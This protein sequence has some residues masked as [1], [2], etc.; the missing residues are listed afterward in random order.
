MARVPARYEVPYFPCSQRRG[1]LGG[2]AARLH[3]EGVIMADLKNAAM[4]ARLNS[5]FSECKRCDREECPEYCAEAV[6]CHLDE[7]I[8]WMRENIEGNKR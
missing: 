5:V 3:G 4:R 8:D 7:V 1:A 2:Q 6:Q